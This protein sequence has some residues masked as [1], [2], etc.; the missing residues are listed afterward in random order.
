MHACI[1]RGRHV[2]PFIFVG[3]GNV[4]DWLVTVCGFR[5]LRG[6]LGPGLGFAFGGPKV[7]RWCLEV[8][9]RF[10]RGGGGETELN[11]RLN[12]NSWYLG[13]LRMSLPVYASALQK[14]YKYVI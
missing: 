1:R 3:V 9:G 6:D 14:C 4:V 7:G 12:D 8:G 5:R 2:Q 13:M 11:G 10:R